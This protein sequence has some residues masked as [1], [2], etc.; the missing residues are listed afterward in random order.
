MKKS[1]LIVCLF[2]F[3]EVSA[4]EITSRQ[5]KEDFDYF[6]NTINDNYCYWDKKQTDWEKVK[7]VY[8]PL[9][10]TITSK[11]SFVLLL[12]KIFYELYDHHASLNTNT[13]ESQRLVPSGTD[14]WAEYINGKPII[15]EVRAGF[16]AE[17]VGIRAGMQIVGFND[18]PVEKA[19]QPFLPKCL[20]KP[21][22]ESKNYALR[23]L[24]AGKHSENRKITVMYQNQ[25]KEFYPDQPVNLLESHQYNND[26]DS[27][28]F[29]GNIGY[30]RI[31]N[32][33]GDNNMIPLFDSGLTVLGNTKAI[34]L[35]L[36]ETPSGGNTMV[37]RSI[38]GHFI[39]K[40]G[41][42]Q[43]HELTSEEKEFGIRRSWVEIV[44]PR[45]PAYKKPLV[46]LV[47]HWTGSVAEGIAIGFDALKSATIT[48][49]DMAGLNGAVY[50]FTMPHTNIG[51][52]FPAEKLFHVNGSPREKFKPV[53]RVDVV[54]QKKG[55][56][57][58][59][60]EGLDYLRKKL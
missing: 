50:S 47:D 4:Q 48:G 3:G 30:I 26:L 8:G 19:I 14:L 37:A 59:L 51:F 45:K 38:L 29:T 22:G 31:N 49:T 46:V 7:T 23:I 33:L 43:K 6:W 36:R 41:F 16:G 52:S 15:T 58:I 42:Y 39:S 10:D 34:I 35:D 60:Q 32:R 5:Y 54:K 57:L 2:F 9:V 1:F 44:S 24:L 55:E 53:I 21:D 12:E 11:E 25:L 18:V 56:D 17:K 20:Q 13:P 40:E 28:I 27:K